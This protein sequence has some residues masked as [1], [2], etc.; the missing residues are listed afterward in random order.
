MFTVPSHE[1]ESVF[2]GLSWLGGN[3]EKKWKT[4]KLMRMKKKNMYN[5]KKQQQQ[6]RY[7]CE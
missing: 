1:H 5:K 7:C 2:E 3:E 4:I 6:Q